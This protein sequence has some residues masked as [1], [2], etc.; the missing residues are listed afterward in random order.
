ME[1][2]Y[3]RDDYE[4][5]QPAADFHKRNGRQIFESDCFDFCGMINNNIP[6]CSKIGQARPAGNNRMDTTGWEYGGSA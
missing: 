1:T 4:G 6:V 5:K 3:G 2:E